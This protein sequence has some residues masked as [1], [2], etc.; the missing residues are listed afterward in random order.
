MKGLRTGI[1]GCV[2]K[3]L[4]FEANVCSSGDSILLPSE[5]R[6]KFIL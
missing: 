1:G 5:K 6:N 4:L 3:K 2:H